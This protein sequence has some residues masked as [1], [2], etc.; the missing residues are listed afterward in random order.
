MRA[1]ARLPVGALDLDGAEDTLA[2]NLLANACGRQLFGGAE[3]H[4]DDAILEDQF[5]RAALS[6]VQ[7]SRNDR[8]RIEVDCA[9]F[10]AKMERHRLKPEQLDKNGGEQMLAGMLLHVIEP[11]RPV[12]LAAH[13]AVRHGGGGV[14]HYAVIFRICDLDYRD[15]RERPEI[16]RLPSRRRV[17]RRAIEHDLPTMAIGT[18]R[19][20]RNHAGLEFL[21]EGVV[22]IEA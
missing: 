7:V 15:S 17:K 11:A 12:D 19:L 9:D 10:A 21:E 4:G 20:A 6:F 1:S 22:V 3:A 18:V 13:R 8:G 5:I 14:M 2:V 16:V